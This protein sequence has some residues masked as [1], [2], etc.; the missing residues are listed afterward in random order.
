MRFC[1]PVGRDDMVSAA[2]YGSED[3]AQRRRIYRKPH[4][5][6]SQSQPRNRVLENQRLRDDIANMQQANANW[7]GHLGG[8]MNSLRPTTKKRIPSGCPNATA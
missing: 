7:Q 2:G 6:S 8:E 4:G 1:P 3:R 5:G